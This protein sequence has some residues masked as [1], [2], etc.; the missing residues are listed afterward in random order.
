[1][2]FGSDFSFDFA[3]A[4]T[5]AVAAAAAAAT[6]VAPSSVSSVLAQA[7]GL[8]SEL[9]ESVEGSRRRRLT[10]NRELAS[11]T[12]GSVF[13][14]SFDGVNEAICCSISVLES[15]SSGVHCAANKK[16]DVVLICYQVQ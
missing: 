10:P 11:S 7:A 9:P 1:M 14:T 16:I 13:E 5:A 15:N 3:F 12:L 2:N 8:P 4:P 6:A